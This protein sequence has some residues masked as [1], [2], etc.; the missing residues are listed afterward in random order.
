MPGGVVEQHSVVQ[1][2]VV[3]AVLSQSEI[4]LRIVV[5]IRLPIHRV[6]HCELQVL[7]SIVSQQQPQTC[8]ERTDKQTRD[9]TNVNVVAR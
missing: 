1:I 3:G 4:S 8:D 6:A 2:H 7:R 5:P 9:A